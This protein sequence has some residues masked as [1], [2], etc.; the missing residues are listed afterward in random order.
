MKNIC[1]LCISLRQLIIAIS[2]S[3]GDIKNKHTIF[4]PRNFFY[5][6]DDFFVKL[7]GVFENENIIFIFNDEEY[8][9]REFNSSKSKN[10]ICR[11]LTIRNKKILT[12][13]KWSKLYSNIE[14]FD[15]AYLYHSGPFLAKILAYSS[16]YVVLKEDGIANYCEHKLT[17]L[18]SIIRLFFFLNPRNQVWGEERWIDILDVKYPEKLPK[19]VQKKSR[20]N[21]FDLLN[22]LKTNKN[23]KQNIYDLFSIDLRFINESQGKKIIIMTQPVDQD[24]LISKVDKK[25]IYQYIIDFFG[26]KGSVFLKQHPR[27]F[28][29]IYSNVISLDKNFPIEVISNDIMFDY[30]ISLCSTASDFNIAENNLSLIEVKFFKQEYSNKWIDIIKKKLHALN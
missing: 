17:F 13:N 6:T 14:S 3:Y 29:D 10:I 15:I 5:N 23:L 28:S 16:N 26:D 11:N 18:K 7:K 4:A 20:K 8:Y 25:I 1:H 22:K 12:L 30:S 27:E 19:R 9:L 2:E 21:Q 24:N